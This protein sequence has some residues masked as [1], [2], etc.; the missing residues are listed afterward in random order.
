MFR[1][2]YLGGGPLG[3]YWREKVF[4]TLLFDKDIVCAKTT[5]DID[6]RYRF[7]NERHSS[8]ITAVPEAMSR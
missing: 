3:V 2:G 4:E 7:L 1:E 5:R 8:V 6:D